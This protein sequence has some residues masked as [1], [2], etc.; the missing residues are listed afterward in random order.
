MASS[1]WIL[2]WSA[3]TDAV[4]QKIAFSSRAHNTKNIATEPKHIMAPP[5]EE[6]QKENKR[7]N[8]ILLTDE[9]NKPKGKRQLENEREN[10]ALLTDKDNKRKEEHEKAN[11]RENATVLTDKEN[12]RYQRVMRAARYGIDPFDLWEDDW[13]DGEN[14]MTKEELEGLLDDMA[15]EA[16]GAVA[17][18]KK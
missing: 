16:R 2:P 17:K 12:S 10:E 11:E 7:E 8:D 4:P 5:K 9:E 14:E 6:R 15:E 18:A 3:R 1:E 13:D